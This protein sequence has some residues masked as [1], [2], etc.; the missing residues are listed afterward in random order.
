MGEC[1][2]CTVLVDGIVIDS[3]LYF[4]VW[5]EGKE[6]RTLE[7]EAKGGKFFYV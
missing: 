4:V 3:C 1:G 7:G 2:V 5:V 6:I